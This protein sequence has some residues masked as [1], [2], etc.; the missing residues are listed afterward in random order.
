M[1]THLTIVLAVLMSM[2][3]ITSM[4]YNA[5]IDDVY[6]NLSG[7][8]ATVTYSEKNTNNKYAYR[9]A[10]VIPDS[11]IWEDKVY[12]VTA[13]GEYAFSN[14]DAMTSI[15]LP[16]SINTIGQYAFQNC[17]TLTSIKIP[18]NLSIID[19]HVFDGCKRIRELQIPSKVTEIKDGAF[20]GCSSVRKLIIDDSP[21]PL[22]LGWLNLTPNFYR[23]LK[24]KEV[25]IGRDLN[26]K[27]YANSSYNQ[28]GSPFFENDSLRVAVIGEMV[29]QIGPHLFQRC[30][31]LQSIKIGSN[32]REIKEFAFN[33]CVTLASVFIPHNVVTIGTD[34]F[35]KCEGLKEAIIG[36]SVSY[37]GQGAFADCSGLKELTI[38]KSVGSFGI[39]LIKGS[40]SLEHIYCFSKSAPKSE[41][42][43][44]KP[45]STQQSNTQ[46]HVPASS[47]NIYKTANFWKEFK[48]IVELV[49][50]VETLEVTENELT[51]N[52]GSKTKLG[53]T[54]SP[55]DATN[56][57]II[58]TSSDSSVVTIDDNSYLIGMKQGNAWVKVTSEDNPEAKDSCLVTVVEPVTGVTISHTEYALNGIGKAIQLEAAVQPNDATN[59]GVTW[60]SSNES[61]C[62]VKDG[63]VTAKGKGTAIISVKTDDGGFTASCTVTVTQAVTGITLNYENYTLN[64]IGESVQLTATVTPEDADNK[65]ITWAS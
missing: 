64:N 31:N 33:S 1:K 47:I 63:L 29:T 23:T 44:Y 51:V 60:S 12:Y 27:E 59:K 19:T 7:E 3:T 54:I 25:Y 14:C 55:N 17:S 56:K 4:A 2:V 43:Y 16:E 8:K 39:N 36:N 49:I 32:V 28:S 35:W 61:V 13:I 38:G 6:Y 22:T 37:I 40:D 45:S 52:V 15:E 30:N 48:A 18:Q 62:T 57:K 20:E 58:W 10:V 50:G 5:Y 41:N 65:A 11:V 34:A 24:I 9:G 42:E 46:L 21:S 26:Y 53:F